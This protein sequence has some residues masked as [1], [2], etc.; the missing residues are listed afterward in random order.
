[1]ENTK[2]R[3]KQMT[4]AL[5]ITQKELAAKAQVRES[6]ISNYINDR[7]E[8]GQK[9]LKKIADAFGI[10]AAWL[11]GYGDDNDMYNHDI[12]EVTDD[13]SDFDKEL[14]RAYQEASESTKKTINILLDLD[15]E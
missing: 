10:S 4:A 11:M 13:I 3:L 8:P 5:G 14:L 9:T 6:S 12:F 2:N 15:K 1:M 7:S